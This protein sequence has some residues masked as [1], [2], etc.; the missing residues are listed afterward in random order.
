[1]AKTCVHCCAVVNCSY[2]G[3]GCR[4]SRQLLLKFRQS[5]LLGRF[6]YWPVNAT[7]APGHPPLSGSGD[8]ENGRPGVPT[9][10][11]PV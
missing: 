9:G 1:M 2:A 8:V 10:Y 6:G 7:A 4:G 5:E 3:Q 11:T